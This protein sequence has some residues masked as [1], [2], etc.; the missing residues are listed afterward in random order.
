MREAVAKLTTSG[1][2]T[3]PG[4]QCV[5]RRPRLMFVVTEDLCF[6]S[7]RL[8]ARDASSYDA[9]VDI[10]IDRARWPNQRCRAVAPLI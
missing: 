8:A 1:A 3:D 7:H 10:P 4:R 5:N 9:S 6:V 2:A